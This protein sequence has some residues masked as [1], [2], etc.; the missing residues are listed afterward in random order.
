MIIN[1]AEENDFITKFIQSEPDLSFFIGATDKE[2]E[3]LWT[4]P[5]GDLL[6]YTNWNIGPNL[7]SEPNGGRSENY[8]VIYPGNFPGTEQAKGTWNDASNIKEITRGIAE[9]KL[10]LTTPQQERQP[11]TVTSKSDR[12][13]ASMHQR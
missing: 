4:D 5:S 10:H 2:S 8:G 3:S 12:P 13:S 7:T 1:D 9:I 6:T 11:S